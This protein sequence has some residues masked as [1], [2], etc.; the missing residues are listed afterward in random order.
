MSCASTLVLASTNGAKR[1][2]PAGAFASVHA[3]TA[4]ETRARRKSDFDTEFLLEG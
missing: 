1:A 4:I 2:E 3:A